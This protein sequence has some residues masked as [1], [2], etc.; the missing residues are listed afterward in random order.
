[1]LASPVVLAGTVE[2]IAERLHE[3]RERWGYS[4]YTVQQPA[5]REMAAVVARLAGA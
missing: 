1:V 5:A 3:R 4:Y 2:E